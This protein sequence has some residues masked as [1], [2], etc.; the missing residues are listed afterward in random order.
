MKYTHL[1]EKGHIGRL[2]I[3]NRI[4]MPAMDS[5][6][7]ATTGEAT[8]EMIRYFEERSAGG[9][10]LVI[11]EITRI[12]NQTGIG[13]RNQLGA[14]DPE[15]IISLEKL[16]EAVHRHE[17]KIF[18]QLQH[19]GAE[20]NPEY[21][22]HKEL[23]APSDVMCKR[24]GVKPRPMTTEE[25]DQMVGKFVKGARLAQLA[26][27]DVMEI[28]GAHGYLINQFLSPL[29]NHRIDKYGG[30]F[31]NR[32]RF[33]TS[34]INGIQMICGPDFPISVRISA[35]EFMDGG[36]VLEEGVKIAR[37]LESIGIAV[38]NVSS[39]AYD[40]LLPAVE[41]MSFDEGWRLY[42]ARAVKG[43]VKIPVIG[44]GVIRHPEIAE[45]A[46]A[47]GDC[48]FVALGRAHLADPEWG[49]KTYEGRE[50]E[51]RH[52]ISCLYCW[53]EM[54][55]GRVLKC[56]VNPRMGRE[57]IYKEFEKNGNSR[58]VVV[59]GGGP[60]G[61]EAASVL[62][63]RGFSPVLFEKTADLGGQVF[64]AS[65]LP[66]KDKVKW[67]IDAM[68]HQLET[69]G[70]DMR[71]NTTPTIKDIKTLEPYAVFLATGAT[72]KI[73]PVPGID[74]K[75]VYTVEQI[76]RHQAVLEGQK[77]IVLG[78]GLTGLETV[79]YLAE[80]G[81]AVTVVEVLKQIG[82]NIQP[83]LMDDLMPRLKKYN[84]QFITGENIIRIDKKSIQVYNDVLRS[85]KDIEMDSLVLS[86]GAQSRNDFLPELQ[87]NFDKVIV[88]GDA[89]KPGK[90]GTAVYAGFDRA[91]FL[92]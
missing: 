21:N 55:V 11:T 58:K 7:A 29:T 28:H 91:F 16:A 19:P 73:P 64:F 1:F 62:A 4:V 74:G 83:I 31:P 23:I 77:V 85:F 27:I 82:P 75:N 45:K 20:G 3:R 2:E 25:V 41:P 60:A 8:P 87:A 49:K 84:V 54:T 50:K 26:G 34:I 44:V 52:C 51:I 80:K 48:D 63:I 90:I 10:G 43:A 68:R 33:V 65:A 57:L 39:G 89:D 9:A 88:I 61:M 69:A 17:A 42:L 53:E 76:L 30:S 47:E 5:T 40:S 71:L 18:V 56:A 14:T 24:I 46:I 78:S 6:L 79:E 81:N 35:E 38:I 22:T 15:H 72:P 37:Y 92:Q 70:V 67:M 32:M 13:T 86:I 66:K 59:I 36:I 12:D